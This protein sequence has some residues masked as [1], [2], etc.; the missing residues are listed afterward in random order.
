MF[1]CTSTQAFCTQ[2][3]VTTIP[4]NT[5]LTMV[6]WRDDREPFPNS[7]NRWFYA[8]LDN[9]QEG[10]VWAPQVKN[11]TPNTPNCSTINWILSADWA[12][13]H[14]GQ[15]NA[16]TP[17]GYWSGYCATFTNDAWNGQDYQPGPDGTAAQI[18]QYYK[19]IGAV[20]N[21]PSRPP[22]GAFVFFP[23]LSSQG[24]IA[25]SLGNWQAVGTQ[26]LEGQSLPVIEFQVLSGSYG[27][28][29][30]GWAMPQHPTVPQDPS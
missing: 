25:L 28:T 18:Y 15:R 4:Q 26:G 23:T 1:W 17:T 27:S 24:H 19:G 29:Y 11:Q 21:Y 20:H 6:C 8:W 10:Y 7:S 5:A 16:K 12:I 9:G 3:T 30:A 14:I 2:N 13:G 22:R